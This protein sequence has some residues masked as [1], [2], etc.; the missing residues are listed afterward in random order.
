VKNKYDGAIDRSWFFPSSVND[1]IPSIRMDK[2][3]E[4]TV[5]ISLLQLDKHIIDLE[6]KDGRFIIS[7]V[8]SGSKGEQDK[9]SEPA[10][11]RIY[12][13]D[14]PSMINSIHLRFKNGEREITLI[15]KK[16]HPPISIIEINV[17]WSCMNASSI[18]LN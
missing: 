1:W 10:L 9:L 14:N 2:A 12:K 16:A 13:V 18:L 8:A 5:I 7:S 3:D 11:K 6:Y 17:P 4:N 15:D